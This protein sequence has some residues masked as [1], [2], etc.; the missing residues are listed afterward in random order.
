MLDFLSI[1]FPYRCGFE[2][3]TSHC[4]SLITSAFKIAL[5]SFFLEIFQRY[6]ETGAISGHCW[7]AVQPQFSKWIFYFSGLQCK[8]HRQLSGRTTHSKTSVQQIQLFIF[9]FF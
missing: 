7:L 6:A 3:H 5:K 8:P 1:S 2:S 4:N 9:L